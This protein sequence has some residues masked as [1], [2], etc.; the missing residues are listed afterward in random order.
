MLSPFLLRRRA[1]ETRHNIPLPHFR[2]RLLHLSHGARGMQCSSSLQS[3][4]GIAIEAV[5]EGAA[6]GEGHLRG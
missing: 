6:E 5:C 3:R 1:Q 2:R 4:V